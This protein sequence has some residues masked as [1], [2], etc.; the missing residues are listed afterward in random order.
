M[1]PRQPR[2]ASDDKTT[3]N[4]LRPCRRKRHLRC[5]WWSLQGGLYRK[6][7]VKFP[8]R[9]GREA[10]FFARRRPGGYTGGDAL[11]LGSD[12]RVAGNGDRTGRG[13]AAL[14][15]TGH[16]GGFPLA[17]RPAAAAG[18]TTGAAFRDGPAGAGPGAGGRPS[19]AGPWSLSPGQ[20]KIFPGP[21]DRSR[22]PPGSPG[23]CPGAALPGLPALEPAGCSP[24]GR[25]SAAGP[26]AGDRAGCRGQVAGTGPE[27]AA[28][29]RKNRPLAG[30]IPG[31]EALGDEKP[32]AP[33]ISGGGKA[34]EI[35]ASCAN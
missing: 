6:P 4:R 31:T 5:G 3:S 22:Q 9:I 34:W 14:A 2:K 18:A 11:A 26:A 1:S 25:G 7:Q 13:G 17:A 23:P 15:A 12:A 21:G 27:P 28:T 8:S 29:H 10:G 19:V 30:R 35:G 24:G 33:A 16:R 20:R 32:A